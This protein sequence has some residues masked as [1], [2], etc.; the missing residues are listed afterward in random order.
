LFDIDEI[1]ERA[2]KWNDLYKCGVIATIL[3]I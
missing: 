3:I 1:I 2:K